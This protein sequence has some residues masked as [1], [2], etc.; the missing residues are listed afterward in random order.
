VPG[1]EI[2]M[3]QQKH[4]EAKLQ[5][6]L[7]GESSGGAGTLGR[8]ISWWAFKQTAEKWVLPDS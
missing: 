2:T 1:T 8:K 4:S 7:G 3:A 6:T 5:R